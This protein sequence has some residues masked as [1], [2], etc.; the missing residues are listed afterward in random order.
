MTKLPLPPGSFGLPVI[1][2][3]I[4]FLSD[5]NYVQTRYDRYGSIFKSRV[6]GRP[7][8]FMAGAEAV[9]FLLSSGFDHF[10]WADGWPETFR[11]LLGRSLFLQEG[12]EH[13]RNRRLIMPAF[14]GPALAR[15][16]ETMETITQRYL[17]KW[18]RQQNFE[19][20]LEFKQLTFDI[21]SQIFLGTPPGEE[22]AQLSQLFTTLTNGLFSF[23]NLPGSKLRRAIAARQSLLDHLTTVIQQRKDNPTD[24]ALSLLIAAQDEEGNRLSFEEIQNQALLLL[25]AGHETTTAMLTWFT[26]E[27]GRHPE[28]WERAIAEQCALSG[29]ITPESLTKMPYLDQ[30]L[31]E[32]ERLHP[33]VPGGF[34]G[35]IKPFEFNGYHIP[36]GWMA[37]YSILHTHRLPELY[38]DPERFDVDRWQDTKPKPFNLVGFGGGSRICI[39]LS[40]AKL[41]MKLIAA[42]LLRNY[43]WELLPQ[44]LSPVL[45]PTRRPK[46]NLKVKFTRQS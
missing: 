37:Q 35:V 22:T 39:G 44:D 17:Q 18:E 33:P 19:W 15:Y 16:F 30:I 29:D 28:V 6:I 42:H 25:F 40:F 27:L 46:D 38:P 12:E 7:I 34:R 9:E 21:A 31:N 26:L 4:Q 32:V 10:S 43:T 2:E 41:E 24:D 45:V 14:H 5:P 23:V 8:V 11:L 20:Y 1:G 3:T 13:R 36:A